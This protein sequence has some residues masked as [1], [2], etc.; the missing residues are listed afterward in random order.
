MHLRAY[1]PADCQALAEL[2][3]ATVHAVNRRDYT[4]AQRDAWTRGAGDLA[5]W[6][7]SFLDHITLV[8]EEDGVIAGFGDLDAGAGYLDRLY[9]HKD[10]QRRGI[11]SALCDALEQAVPGERITT[12]ASI[13]AKPFFL[14]RGYQIVREQQV[15]RGGIALTNYVMEKP[16]PGA[17]CRFS[18]APRRKV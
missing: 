13:T 6:N 14:H 10:Y 9:I 3:C 4:A 5:A 11:A 8:A 15:F 7:R 18:V 2:F 1:V 16:L 12:H 17:S